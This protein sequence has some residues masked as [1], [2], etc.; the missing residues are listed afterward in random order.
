MFPIKESLL[1]EV[2]YFCI[3]IVETFT[4]FKVYLSYMFWYFEFYYGI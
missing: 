2:V 1:F 3:E 4:H